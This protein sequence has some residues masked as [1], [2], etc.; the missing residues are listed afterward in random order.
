MGAA[1]WPKEAPKEAQEAPAL[2]DGA[3]NL[4]DSMCGAQTAAP[5][6]KKEKRR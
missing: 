5:E 6:G 3:A 1:G 2:I 4:L